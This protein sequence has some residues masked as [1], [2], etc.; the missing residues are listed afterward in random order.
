MVAKGPG[1]PGVTLVGVVN[2]DIGLSLRTSVRRSASSSCSP[3]WRAGRVEERRKGKSSSRRASPGTGSG[4]C[5]DAR[6]VGVRG[7]R[8]AHAPAARQP[9]LREAGARPAPRQDPEKTRL[10]AE[11]LGR[12]ARTLAGDDVEL[13]GPVA[14][15]IERIKKFWRWHLTFR[16]RERPQAPG[17]GDRSPRA[18]RADET[19]AERADGGGRRSVEPA[20]ST[21]S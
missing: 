20:L 16:G 3:R 2:A 14:A 12:A 9:T 17:P 18:A 1:F 8:D 5:E 10:T 11:A 13:L 6:R 15:P 19:R 4:V 7:S 21:T